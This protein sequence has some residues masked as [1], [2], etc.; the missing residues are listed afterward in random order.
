[1]QRESS[2]VERVRGLLYRKAM[3]VTLSI[4]LIVP[5]VLYFDNLETEVYF[6]VLLIGVSLLYIYQVKKPPI[7]IVVKDALENA[8]ANVRDSIIKLADVLNLKNLRELAYSMDKLEEAITDFINSVE[9]DYERRWGYLG[10]LMGVVGVYASYMVLGGY[11][12]YGV[13]ALIFYDTAS[14]LLGTLLGR[15]KV[16]FSTVTIEG[17]LLGSL[18][19]SLVVGSLVGLYAL[20]A[21]YLIGLAMGIAEAYSGEDNLTIPIVASILAYYLKLPRIVL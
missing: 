9:R 21:L 3:H 1:M 8:R 12:Y 11:A 2:R 18:V 4:P 19:Y 20:P 15:V 16:P 5:L 10:I 6:T 17:I 13:L 14:G 7:S